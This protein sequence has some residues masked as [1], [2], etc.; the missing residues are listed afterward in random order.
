MPPP[1][2]IFT[3][4]QVSRAR[5]LITS[6]HEQYAGPLDPAKC[7]SYECLILKYRCIYCEMDLTTLLASLQFP[8]PDAGPEFAVSLLQVAVN[9]VP[10]LQYARDVAA[11][12][13]MLL[14][15]PAI[16]SNSFLT[17]S[18]GPRPAGAIVADAFRAMVQ[19]RLKRSLH[20]AEPK[21]KDNDIAL[22][23][24]A[25]LGGI[26]SC[27][28]V[29]SHQLCAIS[30]IL[31]YPPLAVITEVESAFVDSLNA[32][33]DGGRCHDDVA[34]AICATV[35]YDHISP[36]YRSRIHA[37][38][39]LTTVLVRTL[40]ATPRLPDVSVVAGP[41]SRFTGQIFRCGA[42]SIGA[43]PFH[44]P[45]SIIAAYTSRARGLPDVREST[46]AAVAVLCGL[47]DGVQLRSR[48]PLG[49]RADP[50]EAA[51]AKAIILI[52][53]DLS[54]TIYD[55]S[56]VGFAAESYLHSA[57]VGILIACDG[58]D[59]VDDLIDAMQ[60]LG[61]QQEYLFALN[62]AEKILLSSPA[63]SPF[64]FPLLTKLLRPAHSV[65]AR[66]TAVDRTLIG[67]AIHEAAHAV[68][69][70][71]LL[72]PTLATENAQFVKDTY[73]PHLIDLYDKDGITDA[74]FAAAIRALAN[75]LAPGSGVLSSVA[76][77]I[78]EDV[79]LPSLRSLLRGHKK[80]TVTGALVDAILS[81]A[82]VDRIP[83]WLGTLDGDRD[84]IAERIRKGD[85]PS[86]CAEGIVRWWFDPYVA[87]SNTRSRL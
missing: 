65:I 45:L 86:V 79:L 43:Q 17:L 40:F 49:S 41:L 34:L 68:F 23:I 14:L 74:Q 70:A 54:T 3:G 19:A 50:A 87:T 63:S 1:V 61:Q 31:T 52:L 36:R 4:S 24:L 69:L 16:W 66:P 83:F 48:R 21:L 62:T 75:A 46:F 56:L 42:A 44:E 64:P 59:K 37:T 15:S 67:K 2:A 77:T 82:P 10:D 32:I 60:D 27:Q 81:C 22:F 85:V 55:I 5:S 29:P 76:P 20:N 80:S 33:A 6:P 26:T 72:A 71:S 8:A 84:V 35:G 28:Q 30:G 7:T 25:L 58:C 51:A 13:R 38:P 11:V 73:L 47:V 12:S 57:A 39:L 78:A 18:S 53:R 9:I